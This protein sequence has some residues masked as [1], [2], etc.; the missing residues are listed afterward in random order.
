[1]ADETPRGDTGPLA[2]EAMQL[3]DAI[4]NEKIPIRRKTTQRLDELLDVL[5]RQ[6]LRD[7][8]ASK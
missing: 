1:M 8:T 6:Y 5:F 2:A 7:H 4:L 3:L